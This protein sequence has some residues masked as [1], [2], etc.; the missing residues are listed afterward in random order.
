[1]AHTTK[2]GFYMQGISRTRKF[3]SVLW[4]LLIAAAMA[5]MVIAPA[6]AFSGS[7]TE[8]DPYVIASQTDLQQ[9][10]ADVNGGNSYAGKYFMLDNDIAL[11]GAWTPIGKDDEHAFS[12]E[13][14]GAGNSIS[15]LYIS[16]DVYDYAGLFGVV[17]GDGAAVER[18]SV[19]GTVNNSK[20]YGDAGLI[21]GDIEYGTVLGCSVSGTVTADFAAGGI[22]GA[23]RSGTIQDSKA[24]KVTVSA[25]GNS[26][27]AGGIVGVDDSDDESENQ[28]LVTNCSVTDSKITVGDFSGTSGSAN[29]GG[30]VGAAW[31][32][33]EVSECT[34]SGTTITGGNSSTSGSEVTSI[35]VNVGGVVGVAGGS[36]TEIKDC[37]VTSSTVKG[38][39]KASVGGV[40]GSADEG[41]FAS[42][43]TVDS[44]TQK[45]V[46]GGTGSKV[47]PSGIGNDHSSSGSGGTGSCNAGSG[48][49]AL[50]AVLPLAWRRKK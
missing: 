18:L 35:G 45:A 16:S 13:F 24:D 39:N 26:S 31:S 49:L 20:A 23:A 19:S 7:G 21:A 4:A 25:T 8:A 22:A 32:G 30:A 1:M 15:N 12:G 42:G 14:D 34:V 3:S 27:R 33:S 47:S 48:A 2:E 43:N 38:G 11:S 10:A 44:V 46:T 17:S 28:G 29:A 36:K 5:V 50:L 9:L 40:G 41:T 6:N 37:M